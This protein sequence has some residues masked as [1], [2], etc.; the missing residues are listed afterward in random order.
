[1]KKTSFVMVLLCIILS[2]PTVTAYAEPVNNES[3]IVATGDG[4]PVDD[5]IPEEY[6]FPA[7]YQK[8]AVQFKTEDG[9][10]LCGWVLG[11]G[12]KGVTIGH[13]NGWKPLSCLPFAERLVEEGYMVI[14]WEFR[15]LYPS[16]N[17]PAG[18]E[19]R[20]DL[21]VLAATQVLRERGAT[22]IF[23]MGASDGGNATAVASPQIPDLVGLGILSSPSNSKGDGQAALAQITVPSFFAVSN[24]D[25]GTGG[26]DTFLKEVQKLYDACASEQK[27]MHILT[28]YEHGTDLLSDADYYSA[29]TPGGS[30]EEQKQERRQLADDLVKFI[31]NAFGGNDSKLDSST[32]KEPAAGSS[33]N[34]PLKDES[35]KDESSKNEEPVEAKAKGFS[36]LWIG[37]GVLAIAGVALVILIKRKHTNGR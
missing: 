35:L 16:G 27:E 34:E 3:I 7:K 22:E 14:I 8:N 5:S 12:T 30:T 31:N 11:E 24:N 4:V 28:S 1:M 15:N 2:M 18:A 23:A 25:P 33:E 26:G 37:I 13:A 29:M 9:V 21:D 36:M 32:P 20:W 19:Q 17:A 10:L 6:R